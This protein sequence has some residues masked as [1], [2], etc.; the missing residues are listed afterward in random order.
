M[1]NGV[2]VGE[3]RECERGAFVCVKMKKKE[4]KVDGRDG[5]SKGEI[6]VNVW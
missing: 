4:N 2:L 5:Q 1:R 6:F 3:L